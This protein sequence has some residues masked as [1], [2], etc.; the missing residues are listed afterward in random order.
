MRSIPGLI[1]P[2][3]GGRPRRQRQE[4]LVLL[5]LVALL[6]II[7]AILS[8]AF[9]TSQNVSNILNQI[10]PI[11]FV[12]LG[13]TLPILT[14]GIDLSVGPLVSLTT[15]LA[16]TLMG[17]DT[18][19]VLT[20][21][22]ICLAVGLAVGLVNGFITAYLSVPPLIA[23]LGTMSVVNG[24]AL[25]VLPY[26][27]GYVPRPFTQ[28]MLGRIGD[29]VPYSFVYFAVAALLMTWV[30]SSTR[31]GRRVYAVGGHEE[32]ARVAGINVRAVLMGVYVLS[33]LFAT[34][35]GLALAARMYSGDPTA[36]NPF[37]MTSVAAVL[38]GGTTFEGGRGGIPGTVLGVFVIGLLPVS[39]NLLGVSPFI[40][41]I[42]SGAIVV[43]AGL[44]S[45]LRK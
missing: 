23:T 38:I 21:L 18:S 35:G 16:A 11:G 22:L 10:A 36:G 9:R 7:P 41:D 24:V 1:R 30:M 28:A 42:V 33:S 25:M 3:A 8:P 27:G 37:T 31:F 43:L 29:V 34:L 5:G 45:S 19:S 12:A 6:A 17:F 26:P 32:R 2:K 4:T 14:K 40:Q 20:G 15:V 13:Q 39:L 44:Y